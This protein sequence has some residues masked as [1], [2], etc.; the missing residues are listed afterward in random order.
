[1]KAHVFKHSKYTGQGNRLTRT[2]SSVTPDVAPETGAPGASQPPAFA[3]LNNL[4]LEA[5][6]AQ[7][8]G[9]LKKATG[10]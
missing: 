9:Q 2:D 5:I 4:L 1:M 3:G 7:Q 8:Q 10:N 6:A